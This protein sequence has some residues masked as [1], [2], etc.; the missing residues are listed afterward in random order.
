MQIQMQKYFDVAILQSKALF[1]QGGFGGR[2]RKRAIN[3][4]SNGQPMS[5]KDPVIVFSGRTRCNLPCMRIGPCLFTPINLVVKSP[6]SIIC[7]YG[8]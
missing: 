1:P 4:N 5:S 3:L 7:K 8:N 6:G 2:R